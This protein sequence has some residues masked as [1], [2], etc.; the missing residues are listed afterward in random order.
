MTSRHLRHAYGLTFDTDLMLPFPPGPAPVGDGRRIRVALRGGPP[1]PAIADIRDAGPHQLVP[2]VL[3][4]TASGWRHDV[5]GHGTVWFA[6]DGGD[7]AVHPAG[8]SGNA[9]LT[10][11]ATT[12]VVPSLCLAR[13]DLAVHASGVAVPG[14]AVG[15]IGPSGA[16]K[17]TLAAWCVIAGD[18]LVTDDLLVLSPSDRG[19]D[20][21]AAPPTVH[22]LPDAAALLSVDDAPMRAQGDK[23]RVPVAAM[24]DPA[25]PLR[26]LLL[27][28][29]APAG[30]TPRLESAPL[31]VRY[32]RVLEQVYFGPWRDGAAGRRRAA[33]VLALVT[34]TPVAVLVAPR[35]AAAL[36][37]LRAMVHEAAGSR[38]RSPALL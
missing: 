27:L 7:V 3:R 36:P 31:P 38:P 37:A 29:P 4:A 9:A 26:A 17:S 16:G 34:T 1:P 10:Q 28:T 24:A 32:G 25:T 19:Y 13:G 5:I 35:D 21:L 33:A 2:S 12:R 23:H 18:P 30:E 15:I 22:L 14:G 8:G 20:A 6:D 11:V